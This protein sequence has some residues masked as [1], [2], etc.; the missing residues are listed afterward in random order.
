MKQNKRTSEEIKNAII[1]YF[2]EN[3][4]TFNDCMEELDSYNG[5]LGDDRYYSM[6]EFDEFMQGLTPS[7]V[8]Q[9]T[10]YGGDEDTKNAD[11]IRGEFNPNREYFFYNGYGNLC[12]TDYKDYTGHLD[13]Y[14]IEA[15]QENRS[16]IDTIDNT[17][18]LSELFDEL[19]ESEKEPDE[20]AI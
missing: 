6:Y 1:K 14:A 10:F 19:D 5:Y 12:S 13:H 16:Y 17:T 9:R 7:E 2:E 18:E 8:L 3:E 4:E 11:G 20:V 15:M